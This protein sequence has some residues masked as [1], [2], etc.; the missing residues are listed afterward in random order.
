MVV[1][2][3]LTGCLGASELGKRIILGAVLYDQI[4]NMNTIPTIIIRVKLDED[5][6]SNLFGKHTIP[7]GQRTILIEPLVQLG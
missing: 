2:F 1:T 5:I 6:K 3:T 7:G 4:T